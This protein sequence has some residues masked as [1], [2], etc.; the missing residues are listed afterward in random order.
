MIKYILIFLGLLATEILIAVYHFHDVIRYF[1]GDILV[2]PL[3]YCF[4]RIFFQAISSERLII[5]VLLFAFG[6][7]TLQYFQYADML[8]IESK[9]LKTIMGTTFELTDLLAYCIGAVI[10]FTLNRCIETNE[11]DV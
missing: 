9:V 6:I 5:Y 8:R 10:T 11:R 3:I 2:I 7:E 1:V 4:L